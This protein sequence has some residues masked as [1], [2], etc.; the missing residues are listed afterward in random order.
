MDQD[1]KTT[2]NELTE[3]LTLIKDDATFESLGVC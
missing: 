3:D 2:Q 1:K